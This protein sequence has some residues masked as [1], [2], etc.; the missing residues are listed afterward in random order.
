MRQIWVLAA[1]IG[2]AVKYRPP[3]L[4]ARSCRRASPALAGVLN[5]YQHLF[6]KSGSPS[7]TFQYQYD[8]RWL[9]IASQNSNASGLQARRLNVA[10]LCH[11]TPAAFMLIFNYRNPFITIPIAGD[12]QA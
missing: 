7:S 11:M 5:G 4:R 1:F 8:L 10:T 9:E 3:A 12:I 6:R 2:A